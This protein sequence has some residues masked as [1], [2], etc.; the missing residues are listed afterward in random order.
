MPKMISSGRYG[1]TNGKPRHERGPRFR[2]APA[3]SEVTTG[4]LKSLLRDD[5]VAGRLGVVREALAE[6]RQEGAQRLA[7][8]EVG[9]DRG[10]PRGLIRIGDHVPTRPDQARGRL[11]RRGRRSGEPLVLIHLVELE[12]RGGLVRRVV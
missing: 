10:R 3:A 5:L 8:D 6:T 7:L 12:V 2:V 1:R 11:L 4:E 9:N